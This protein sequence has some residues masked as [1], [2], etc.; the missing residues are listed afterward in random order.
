[1]LVINTEQLGTLDKV[2]EADFVGRAATFLI[3][4]FPEAA[5][6]PAEELVAA[7]G[8]QI[9]K[10]KGYGLASERQAAA[11]LISAWLLGEDFDSRF[12]AAR[13]ALS[14]TDMS[15]DE[16]AKWL[17]EWTVELFRTLES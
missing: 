16:K 14:V 11:Y 15:A 7:V 12:P 9:D 10:A 2:A 8:R 3:E 13:I 6:L 4:S 5:N 1:M 17:E